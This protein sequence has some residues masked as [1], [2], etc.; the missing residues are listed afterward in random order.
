MGYG[1]V[2]PK[3]SLPVYSVDTEEEAKRLVTLAC[4]ISIEGQYYAPELVDEQTIENLFRFGERL[5][6]MHERMRERGA[7]HCQ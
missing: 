7:C 5:N 3:G 2:I 4:P 1:P 6:T